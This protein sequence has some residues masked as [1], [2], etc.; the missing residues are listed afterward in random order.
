[1]HGD[2]NSAFLAIQGLIDRRDF[3]PAERDV[4]HLCAEQPDFAPGWHAAAFIA[5]ERRDPHAALAHINRALALTP[6]QPAFRLLRVQCLLSLGLLAEARAFATPLIDSLGDAR[7]FDTL[8]TVLQR[9]GD[10]VAAL[11]AYDRGVA[12]E[13]QN[14]QLLFN[15]AAVRRFLGDLEGAEA[16]YDRALAVRPEDY[17]AWRNRSDL[18][19]QTPARNHVA[20]L[21]ALLGHGTP[22]WRGAVQLNY[23]LAKE[24][25]DLGD[26]SRAFAALARG[27]AT[28]RRHLAY[29]V[30]QDVATVDWIIDAFPGE[31]SDARPRATGP[32]GPVFVLGLPR[33]G[34][35]LVD[36][37]LSSHPDVVSAG[38][39]DHFAL[40][41]VGAV[42]Q[43]GSGSVVARRGFV[44][45]SAKVD[46]AALGAA[47]LARAAAAGFAG[48]F[49]DKMPLNYLYCGLIH[50][51]LPGARM[52]H[53]V[54]HPMAVCYAMYKSL[55]Q[56]GYP[57]SY[58]L[59]ELAAYYVAYRRLMQH[60]QRTLPGAVHTL[61]YEALVR[62]QAGE[63]RRLLEYCGWSWHEGCLRF[64]EN[65][66]ATT[67]AS[68][69]QVRRPLYA[70]SVGQWRHYALEL[71][72]LRRALESAGINVEED[73]S[74]TP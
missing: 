10:S 59:E 24:L 14:A 48:R 66:S 52:V 70:T 49:V 35:T 62:D 2:A 71:A 57:F 36:R 39:L 54:R 15:R 26:Y 28:R 16:D 73:P 47:Y 5:L 44:A 6:L 19:I 29:D 32:L 33:S 53:V 72:P 37:I 30:A 42:K 51:A 7:L 55:F 12:L 67:T 74:A 4:A 64:H 56:D 58:D 40:A 50:Q 1:M 11:R 23:A 34:T 27:A 60:W 21:E 61:S 65:P 20:D 17:E 68:A 22:D 13:P 9:A 45:Q 3:A 41:L 25:E 43:V 18:R 69:S 31:A 63:T 46:F 8:G 38:E